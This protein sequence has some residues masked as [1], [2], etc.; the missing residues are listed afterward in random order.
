MRRRRRDGPVAPIP[1]D[2]VA[3]TGLHNGPPTAEPKSHRESARR[4]GL[5]R[6]TGRAFCL[7]GPRRSAAYVA[8]YGLRYGSS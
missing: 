1:R 6:L 3:I 4:R 2:R 5:S 8:K 7:L